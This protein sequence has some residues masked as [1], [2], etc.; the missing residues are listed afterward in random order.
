MTRIPHRARSASPGPAMQAALAPVLILPMA[1]LL[2]W[3][4]LSPVGMLAI[5]L[6]IGGVACVVYPGAR[7]DATANCS[8]VRKER[9]MQ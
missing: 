9:G 8:A 7:K 4:G 1:A 2:F 6:T 3:E 5:L